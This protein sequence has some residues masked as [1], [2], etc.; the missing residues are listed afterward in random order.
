L[1]RSDARSGWVIA[2]GGGFLVTAIAFSFA[3]GIFHPYYVSLLAPFTA[4]LVGASIS[5]LGR[6]ALA[7]LAVAA[8]VLTELA[9]L[10]DTPGS[11]GWLPPVLVVAGGLAAAALTFGRIR[12]V[13]VDGGGF[14]GPGRDGRVGSS[15]LMSAVTGSCKKTSIAPLYDCQGSAL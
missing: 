3:Q 14:G 15:K 9:V 1:R 12:W 4:A 2:V 7:P 8:G 11:L 10:H 6:S 13:L 5:V